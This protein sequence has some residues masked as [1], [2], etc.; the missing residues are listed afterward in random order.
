MNVP[1]YLPLI[2]P[3][4]QDTTVPVAGALS[5]SSNIAVPSLFSA[6][7]STRHY[8][9]PPV[10][11]PSSPPPRKPP[12]ACRQHLVD[13]RPSPGRW[14]PRHRAR[15]VRGDH[16]QYAARC[17]HRGT[18]S[19]L[20]RANSARP[21]AESRPSTVHRVF[22]FSILFIIPE[23]H[24]EFSNAQKMQYYSKNAKQIS[25]ESLSVDLG[26]RFDQILF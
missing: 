11:S 13:D 15:A 9:E 14:R 17:W 18:I 7:P 8:S 1:S 19:R 10:S 23:N 22:S 21:W 2:T 16:A 24:I 6:S 4:L 26:V 25:I 12:G 5:P 3:V 20:A